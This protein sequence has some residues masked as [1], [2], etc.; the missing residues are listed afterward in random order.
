[1][2]R[3]ER[4]TMKQIQ[5]LKEVVKCLRTLN[6]SDTHLDYAKYRMLKLQDKLQRKLGG[7]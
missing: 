7:K 1:M 3:R 2:T 6:K 5:L 4:K